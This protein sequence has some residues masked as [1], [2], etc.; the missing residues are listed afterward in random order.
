MKELKCEVHGNWLV[1]LFEDETVAEKI[2]YTGSVLLVSKPHPKKGEGKKIFD[3]VFNRHKDNWNRLSEVELELADEADEYAD[4]TDFTV[5]AAEMVV[6]GIKG[7]EDGE[8][9]KIPV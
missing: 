4:D 5:L 1:I 9:G 7:Y 6:E 2:F 3:F 8:K